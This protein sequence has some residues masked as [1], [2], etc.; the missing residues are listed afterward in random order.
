M[1]P[2]ARRPPSCSGPAR[3][4]AGVEASLAAL[5]R[6]SGP[7]REFLARF[8]RPDDRDAFLDVARRLSPPGAA[9][10]RRGRPG[11]AGAGVRRL[12]AAPRLHHRLPGVPALPGG[13]PGGGQRPAGAGP[14]P[15][16]AHL[17]LAPAQAPP[18]RGG[19][20]L[21]APGAGAGP[22][23]REG[24]HGY[25]SCSAWD[26]RRCSWRCSSRRRRSARRCW[27][28]WWWALLQAATQIQDPGVAVV[29]RLCAVLGALAVAGPWI[30]ARVVRFAAECLALA[31]RDLAVTTC[32]RP[33]RSPAPWAGAPVL[34]A[35]APGG[36]D[37]ALPG[38][39]ARAGA[40]AAGPGARAGG[41]R[42]PAAARSAVAGRARSPA[43]LRP[44]GGARAPGWSS[45]SW[46][47]SRSRRPG[48]PGGSPTRSAAPR[49]PSC[50][51]RPSGSARAP[52]GPPGAVGGGAGRLGR[53]RPAPGPRPARELRRAAARRALPGRSGCRG[54]APRRLGAG[55]VRRVAG[56]AGGGRGARRRAGAG[57]RGRAPRPSLT[58]A[59][60]APQARAA[61][62]LALLAL[63]A[64]GRRR[65]AGG[66]GWPCRPGRL[67]AMARGRGRTVSGERTEA[68]SAR[69]LREARRRGQVAVSAELTGA[70]ALAGGLV[71]IAVAGPACA[72]ALAQA[73]C[74]ALSGRPALRGRARR[75]PGPVGRRAPPG[76]A[77]PR[78]RGA[79]GRAGGR[80]PPDRLP[81]RPG[82]ALA[83]RWSGSTLS[84][85][86]AAPLARP[87]RARWPWA[88]S[89]RAV[90]LAIGALW[91]RSRTPA[92]W[93]GWRGSMR[94]R[95]GA[96]CRWPV[97]SPPVCSSR[98]WRSGSSTSCASGGGISARCG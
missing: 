45:P 69:R 70:A 82:R 23:L 63:A 12:R 4:S 40:G 42:G 48:P 71:A 89:G 28:A 55:R 66:A 2:V 91:L 39:A 54:R 95:S 22:V 83:P 31:A 1:A 77:H 60:A 6:A 25:R 20:R 72:R 11:G 50:T 32:P 14:D 64:S 97:A 21:A 52:R 94:P 26:A 41:L 87:A 33:A 35:P 98:W 59:G 53:R 16:L 51:S 49:W 93:R 74:A 65:P 85:P 24:E 80:P 3:R 56:R 88:S 62:G 61:I 18:V 19:G 73:M 29:P 8:A 44:R 7:L 43:R 17:G 79:G 46:P 27:S 13:R 38:R 10:A 30:G 90:L 84:R 34:A 78:R 75:S 58:T 9:A 86:A 81:L 96:P 37:L 36:D 57:P 68:P 5:E 15:A 76:R 47:R 67:E 92:R